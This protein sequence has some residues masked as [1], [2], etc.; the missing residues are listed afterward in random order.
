MAAA[1]NDGFPLLHSLHSAHGAHHDSALS[2]LVAAAALRGAAEAAAAS[3]D[4]SPQP[5][6]LPAKVELRNLT[7]LFETAAVTA[8]DMS[9]LEYLRH[10]LEVMHA[11]QVAA[12]EE[13][14]SRSDSDDGAP[15]TPENLSESGELLR[16]D[17]EQCGGDSGDASTAVADAVAAAAAAAAADA[18]VN[19]SCEEEEEAAEENVPGDTEE[20]PPSPHAGEWYAMDLIW[21]IASSKIE[22]AEADADADWSGLASVMSVINN[23]ASPTCP[24]SS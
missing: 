18:E 14:Q 16:R 13:G 10:S 2:S 7:V 17:D 8:G 19:A 9:G 23:D 3:S 21:T 12:A 5:S 24:P 1:A 20:A 6:P 11:R 22:S 4:A 15:A